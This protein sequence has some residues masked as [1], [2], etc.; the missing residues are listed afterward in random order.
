MARKPGPVRIGTC[1]WNYDSWVGLVYTRARRTAAEYL[2]EYAARFPTTEIDSWFYRFPDRAEVLAYAEAVPES[3]RFTAKIPQAVTLT[4]LKPARG[5]EGKG[6]PN[7]EFLSERLFGKFLEAVT[8]LLGRLDALMFEFEYLNRTKMPSLEAFIEALDGFFG[9]APAG[10][11]Y[12][13]ETRNGNYLK[14]AY[15]EFLNRRGLIPV[16]SE[17][18]FLP[19]VYEVRAAHSAVAAPSAVVRLLGGDR[20]EIEEATSGRWD[21]AI[22][23]K[24]DLDEVAAMVADLSG[25]GKAVTVNVNNHYEGSAPVTID[26]LER[27][28]GRRGVK[29]VRP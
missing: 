28:L 21:K 12:A 4:H 17:K 13:V 10:I 14:P 5:A 9:R 15:F 2:A 11:P 7:P 1:S 29:A 27:L 19:H 26:N 24:D 25:E 20:R 8:P 16:Y 18:R 3:F 6:P 22:F 23:P